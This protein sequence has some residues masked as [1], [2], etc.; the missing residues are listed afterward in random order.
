MR[1]QKFRE[2]HDQEWM[3]AQQHPVALYRFMGLDD[4]KVLEI[5]GEPPSAIEVAKS[6]PTQGSPH[7]PGHLLEDMG[8]RWG[9][10]FGLNKKDKK[11][12]TP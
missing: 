9:E 8:K 6:H 10:W 5:F 2:T 7:Q 3:K 1:Y 11:V 4:A 12:E